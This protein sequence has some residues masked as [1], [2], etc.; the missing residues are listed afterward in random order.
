MEA[1]LI[2]LAAAVINRI[3]GGLLGASLPKGRGDDLAALLFGALVGAATGEWWAIVAFA[4]AFRVGEAHGWGHWM[5]VAVQS[6]GA[7]RTDESPIDDLLDHQP[8]LDRWAFYG[9]TLRG[10]LWGTCLAV[11]AG[12]ISLWA[13]LAF[14]A[15]GANMGAVYFATRLVPTDAS[16]RWGLGE[17]AMGAVFGAAVVFMGVV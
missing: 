9:L 1:L 15:A 13:S 8:D 17:Y 4:V 10:I 5:G 7:T 11:P 14:I 16:T 3:R 6:A 12:F 2:I